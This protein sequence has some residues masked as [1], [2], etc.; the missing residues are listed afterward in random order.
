MLELIQNTKSY[1]A[2]TLGLE[3]GLRKL[4]RKLP[5]YLNKGREYRVLSIGGVTLLG[6][7]YEQEAFD[8]AAYK[9]HVVELDRL[10][11]LPPLAVLPA[12]TTYQR[13]AFISARLA[14]AVPYAQLFVPMLGALFT[15]RASGK[16]SPASADE[17]LTPAAQQ[18][19]LKLL[20]RG[21]EEPISQSAMASALGFDAMKASRAARQLSDLKLID[22]VKDGRSNLLAPRCSGRDLWE[23]AQ[24]FLRNPVLRTSFIRQGDLPENA[25]AA[26]DAVLACH[27]DLAEGSMPTV[28]VRK[29][30]MP[31][32]E[33]IDPQWIWNPEE[34][35]RV[36]E[37]IYDPAVLASGTEADPLSVALSLREAA[38]ERIQAALEQ[39]LEEVFG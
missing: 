7:F 38:D 17:Q 1:L 37:W 9:K 11:Q 28:A 23:L 31:G 29:T 14:F 19:L 18:M 15:E 10:T 16:S 8:L 3:V 5:A 22:V 13:R 27:S 33:R 30:A 35:A 34:T 12:M 2:D 25:F 32:V 26:G 20:Y 36:E 6:V 39:M 4:G 24:P 21:S